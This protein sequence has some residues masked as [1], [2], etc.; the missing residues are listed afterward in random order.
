MLSSLRLRYLLSHIQHTRTS[1][2]SSS[3]VHDPPAACTPR[4]HNPAALTVVGR[5]QAL[6][7]HPT[8][9]SPL[10]NVAA[11]R[12]LWQEWSRFY[13]PT[14]SD[15][16]DA[17]PLFLDKSP[18]NML[19][20]PF[21]QVGCGGAACGTCGIR[22]FTAVPRLSAVTMAAHAVCFVAAHVRRVALVVCARD[23]ASCLLGSRRSQVGMRVGG[24]AFFDHRQWLCS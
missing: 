20:A 8:A 14:L 23:E 9:L 24:R 18:E 22:L 6:L 15:S 13:H 19:M 10:V 7:T 21:L 5:P 11:R 3:T 1:Q 16:H 4:V 2:L 17:Q 12:K